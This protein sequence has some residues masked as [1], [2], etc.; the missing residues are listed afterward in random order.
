M[1]YVNWQ[2]ENDYPLIYYS[3]EARDL[4][5]TIFKVDKLVMDKSW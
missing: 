1:I 4:V 2:F 3:K 5:R